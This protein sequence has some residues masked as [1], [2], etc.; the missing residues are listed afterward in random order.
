MA[1]SAPEEGRCSQGGADGRMHT[2]L[3]P[4][5][6]C[7]SVVRGMCGTCR[8]LLVTCGFLLLCHL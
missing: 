6:M 2:L 8:S 1:D 4:G 5:A 3:L 7:Q